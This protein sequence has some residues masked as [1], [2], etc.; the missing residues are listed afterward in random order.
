MQAMLDALRTAGLATLLAATGATAL[1]DAQMDR[2]RYLVES[3]AA[4]G[5]CH[6]PQG[7]N[8][9]LPGMALAGGLTI[10]QPGFSA[11]S[12][13]ITPDLET[14]IG[15]LTVAQIALAIR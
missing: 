1:A 14:G 3:V 10:E 5:N 7:P 11:V 15:K 6:T 9:P 2:G 8:G 13:N 12:A 4:C